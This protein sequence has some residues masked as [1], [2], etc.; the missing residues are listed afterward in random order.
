MAAQLANLTN[1]QDRVISIL[2]ANPGNFTN[3]VSGTVGA[4]S[5]DAEINLAILE[6]DEFIVTSGYFQSVNDSLANPF[7]VTSAPL[8]DR[9]NVPWHHGGVES[10]GSVIEYADIYD[11]FSSESNPLNRSRLNHRTDR[12]VY[13]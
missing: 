13:Q 2:Q 9:D 4:F 11:Y 1:V 7:V 6:S 8:A 10:S 3:V 12:F 5:S